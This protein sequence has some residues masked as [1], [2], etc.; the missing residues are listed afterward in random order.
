M[1]TQSSPIS[2]LVSV[3]S[4]GSEIPVDAEGPSGFETRPI[5]PPVPQSSGRARAVRVLGLAVALAMTS[6]APAHAVER[7]V[8]GE[9]GMGLLSVLASA[10]YGPVKVLYAGAGALTAGFAYALSGGQRELSQVLLARSLRGD[11]LVTTEHLGG[12]R[13]L[14]FI[15]R[16][17]MLEPSI[18]QRSSE[19]YPY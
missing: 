5:R 16:D 18:D 4:V 13:P 12:E 17:P 2:S 10:V 11:Y 6:A 14:V 7:T 3:S 19:A 8:W 9:A 15:G 1:N